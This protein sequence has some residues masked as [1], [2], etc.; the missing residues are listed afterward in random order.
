MIKKN[1]KLNMVID[2]YLVQKP[3]SINLHSHRL[4]KKRNESKV[5][6]GTFD[7]VSVSLKNI[8]S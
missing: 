8:E 3:S 5:S 4:N 7:N 2:H 1:S 6:L